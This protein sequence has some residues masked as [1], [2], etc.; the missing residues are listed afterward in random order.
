M[1][2]FP[3]RSVSLVVLLAA[4]VVISLTAFIVPFII[5]YIRELFL[6]LSG[7]KEFIF[8]KVTVYATCM[9]GYLALLLLNY[10]GH[11]QVYFGFAS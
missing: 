10:S 8:S 11:S 1:R 2:M 6:V 3:S 7:R 9:V 4:F 5:G